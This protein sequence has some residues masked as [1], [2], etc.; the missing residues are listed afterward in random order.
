VIYWIGIKEKLN[1][2]IELASQLLLLMLGIYISI[3]S[4]KYGIWKTPVLFLG[5]FC[6]FFFRHKTK[7]PIIWMVF[8]ALLV[9]DLYLMYLRVANHHFVLTFMTLSVLCYRY[10]KRSDILLKNTQILLV[11]VI[12][13]SVLQKLISNQFISGNFYY[14]MLNRGFL[15]DPFLGFFS[16]ISE[17]TKSN[18]ESLI[19]LQATDPNIG[20]S[21]VLKDVFPNLGVISQVFAMLTIAMEFIVAIAILWKPKS[22]WTH[23]LFIMMIIGILCTRLETGFMA[24]LAISGLFLCNNIKLRLL[25]AIIAMFCVVLVVT[26][27]GYH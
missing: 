15:F 5:L 4:E 18:T 10:H 1:N 24:L 17:V 16:E 20:E 13:A 7:H 3:M 6:W 23:L 21:I 2:H 12:L 19:A 27:L 8:S 22:R 9:F 26:K 14:Y 11:I 25:Y